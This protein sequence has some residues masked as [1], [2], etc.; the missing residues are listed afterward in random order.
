MSNLYNDKVLLDIGYNNT[1]GSESCPDDGIIDKN[2][3]KNY[4]P[5]NK[6]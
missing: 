2:E 3:I 5:I 4:I 6:K 1:N